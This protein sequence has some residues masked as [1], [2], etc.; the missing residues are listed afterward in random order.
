MGWHSERSSLLP[1]RTSAPPFRGMQPRAY[2]KHDRGSFSFFSS[3]GIDIRPRTPTSLVSFSNRRLLPL[4]HAS[5]DRRSRANPSAIPGSILQLGHTR[6]LF[7]LPLILALMKASAQ[8]QRLGLAV[9]AGASGGGESRSST[10]SR[11]DWYRRSGSLARQ[12]RTRRSSQRGVNER[13]QPSVRVLRNVWS[14]PDSHSSFPGTP[15]AP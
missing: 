5:N 14:R 3:I 11:M 15:S 1:H 7:M 2:L 12:R 13:P 4:S 6:P 8:G 9:V 10:I